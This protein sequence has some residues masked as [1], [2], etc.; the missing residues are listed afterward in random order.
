[1]TLKQRHRLG[2]FAGLRE[3]GELAHVDLRERVHDSAFVTGVDAGGMP[4]G[5][6]GC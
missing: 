6:A 3:T 2:E 1:V 4:G 5:R